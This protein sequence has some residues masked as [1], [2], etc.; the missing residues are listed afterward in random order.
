MPDAGEQIEVG[1]PWADAVQR[2]QRRV[3]V[4]GGQAG[5]GMLVASSPAKPKATKKR[6]ANA[7]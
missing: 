1:G 4:V 2:D 6:S 5:E 7:R 3:R